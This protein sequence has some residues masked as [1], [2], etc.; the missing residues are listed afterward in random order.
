[1]DAVKGALGR[2][3]R[4]KIAAKIYEDKQFMINLLPLTFFDQRL[5]VNAARASARAVFKSGAVTSTMAK[6]VAGF[7]CSIVT[8]ALI[9]NKWSL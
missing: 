2:V 7:M 8:A 9:L 6:R 1:L 4:R 3:S 5:A